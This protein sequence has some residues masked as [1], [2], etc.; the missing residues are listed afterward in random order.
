MGADGGSIPRRDELVKTKRARNPDAEKEQ[1]EARV[2][3]RWTRCALTLVPLCTPVAVD[4]ALG[5]MFNKDALIRALLAH[6]LPPHFKH[7]RHL[8]KDT[9]DAKF[10]TSRVCAS[11]S[12]FITS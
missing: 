5:Y 4:K 3:A 9:V 12:S 6:E 11:H 1:E 10:Y 8:K 2:R 7:I